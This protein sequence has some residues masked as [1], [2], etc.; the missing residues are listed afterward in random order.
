MG[1]Y[2]GKILEIDTVSQNRL[3]T[4]KN[5]E[6]CSRKL[7]INTQDQRELWSLPKGYSPEAKF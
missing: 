1:P 7:R 3:N 2:E 4:I 6:I 5:H